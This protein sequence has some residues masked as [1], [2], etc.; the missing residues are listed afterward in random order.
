MSHHIIRPQHLGF[1]ENHSQLRHPKIW[2]FPQ[3]MDTFRKY[4]LRIQ[5]CPKKNK[6]PYNPMTWGWDVSTIKI[7]LDNGKNTSKEIHLQR[8]PYRIAMS[9]HQGFNHPG[10]TPSIFPITRFF[11]P[12]HQR[13][14]TWSLGKSYH[15]HDTKASVFFLNKRCI[16][17]M[18]MT[19]LCTI[20][21]GQM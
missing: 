18:L 11:S 6:I 4:P 12:K 21:L 15:T 3:G 10:W 14:I 9:L 1:H 19:Y 17:Q 8:G 5:T 16:S 13:S 7:L 20:N 2:N